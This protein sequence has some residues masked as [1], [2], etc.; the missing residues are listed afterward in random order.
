M[1]A[2][3]PEEAQL[4]LDRF[5]AGAGDARVTGRASHRHWRPHD[6]R[7]ARRHRAAAGVAGVGGPDDDR[8]EQSRGRQRDGRDPR[9]PLLGPARA[10]RRERAAAA[11]TGLRDGRDPLGDQR[12]AGRASARA[13]RR[14]RHRAQRRSPGPEAVAAAAALLGR[15]G[16]AVVVDLAAYALL[17]E[18]A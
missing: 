15:E 8:G 7:R 12:G 9:E 6:R 16:D 18:G 17:V 14:R 4:S 3:T 2:T 5:L 1:I 11:P 13:G 10:H